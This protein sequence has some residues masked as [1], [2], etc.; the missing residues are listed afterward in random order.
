[1]T[2]E[3]KKTLIVLGIGPGIGRSV[4]SLFAAKRYHHVALIARRAAQL[5]VEKKALQEAV[6]TNV[7]IKTYVADVVDTDAL[8]RALDDADATLGKPECVFYNAARVLPSQL[9]SHDVKE[10]DYDFKVL[11]FSPLTQHTHA[12][13]HL[14]GSQKRKK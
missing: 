8:T 9:L 3:G 13:T 12:R 2:A 1:M 7:T 5:E 6:G 10:I 14:P 4:T 11:I